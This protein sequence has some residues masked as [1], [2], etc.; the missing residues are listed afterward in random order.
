M[1]RGNKDDRA[2]VGPLT[3]PLNDIR[4]VGDALKSLSCKKLK[5]PRQK[6]RR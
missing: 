1:A 6:V 5:S 2:N 3:N 4:L